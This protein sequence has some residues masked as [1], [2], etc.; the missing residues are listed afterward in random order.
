[1]RA[2]NQLPEIKEQKRIYQLAYSQRPGAKEKAKIYLCAYNQRSD[3]KE[4]KPIRDKTY[5]EVYRQRPN[6]KKY[7]RAS[8]LRRKYGLTLEAYESMLMAQGA[9]CAVCGLAK[10][11]NRGPVIDHDHTSGKVRGVLCFS[12]NAGIG[13]L[14]DNP[15][16]LRAAADYLERT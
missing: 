11:G 10:W 4:M 12:C 2:Y 15:K 6:A 8:H 3:V 14:H 7:K 1:M 9:M 13:L 16:R 5:G